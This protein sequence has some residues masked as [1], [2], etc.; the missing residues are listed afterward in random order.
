VRPDQAA[1]R[2][3]IKEIAEVRVGNRHRR[4]HV[5]LRREGWPANHKRVRQLY[6]KEG[7]NLRTKRPRRHVRAARRVERRLAQRPNESWAM[8]FVSDGL[9]D[10]RCNEPSRWPTVAIIRKIAA[11]FGFPA[12]ELGAFFGL[13]CQPGGKGDVWVD[14]IRSPQHGRTGI[15]R[16]PFPW[17]VARP[18]HDAVAGRGVGGGVAQR[19][20][21]AATAQR[22]RGDRGDDHAPLPAMPQAIR[23]RGRSPSAVS[24]VYQLRWRGQPICC[25]IAY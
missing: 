17:A 4:I 14:I 21:L 22:S 19:H 3:R 7:L 12:A 9:I 16:G 23:E 15:G 8:D 25:V 20:P 11:L 10:P 18:R 24:A 13:L 5:L 2:Q 6:R 1:L